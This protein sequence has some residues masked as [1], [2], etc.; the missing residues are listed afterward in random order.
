MLDYS[1]EF[2]RRQQ[3]NT[4]NISFLSS[5][6]SLVLIT[7]YPLLGVWMRSPILVDIN[8]PDIK[9]YLAHF[10]IPMSFESS[11]QEVNSKS[12]R[13]KTNP[14]VLGVWLISCGQ[15]LINSVYLCPR[16]WPDTL[17]LYITISN[18]T[19]KS[20]GVTWIGNGWEL[21]SIEWAIVARM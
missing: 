20:G 11:G 9:F 10:S 3:D 2:H 21:S 15:T 13:S 4:A 6:I 16:K 1:N 17:S 19:V 14:T 5:S 12:L 8:F 7:S 18:K